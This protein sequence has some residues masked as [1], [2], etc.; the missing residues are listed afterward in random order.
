MHLKNTALTDQRS[1]KTHYI[2]QATFKDMVRNLDANK[3][4][5]SDI[6]GQAGI[7]RKTFYFYYGCREDIFLETCDKIVERYALFMDKV[8]DADFT[9]QFYRKF[10]E[11]FAS[12]DLYVERLLC[13]PTY[14]PY[15]ERIIKSC[16]QANRN[17]KNILTNMTEKERL[18]FQDYAANNMFNLYRRW[19]E[20][21]G[22][23]SLEELISFAF[24][25]VYH[26]MSWVHDGKEPDIDAHT[27]VL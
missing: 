5:I 7:S 18:L 27:E 20:L 17:R 15:R 10:F 22:K 14:Y 23:V 9:V 6:A 13:N 12:Q 4:T 2:I 8:D 3:I 24:K 16:A 25:M 26:G 19:V 21:D 11:F 1:I